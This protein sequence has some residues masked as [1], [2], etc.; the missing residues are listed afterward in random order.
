V[1]TRG[2]VTFV[3]DGAEKTAYNHSD[4]YPDGLGLT[5]LEWLRQA[6][7]DEA[8]AI[9]A[10]GLR[11]VDP[12]SK[13]SPGDIERLKGFANAGVGTQSLDDWYVLLRETQG[14]PALM[15]EAGVIEDAHE[16]PRS[17]L[18]AEWGYV[19]DFD[20]KRFEVY[21]GFQRSRHSAGRFAGREPSKNYYPVAL[22]AAW[23]FD[24]L[25]A[26]AD[27]MAALNDPDEGE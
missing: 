9:R 13:P 18:F 4:S 7:A 17:S 25:P 21:R 23:A 19:A 8:T 12:E 3:I 10:R 1:S 16:F 2:F 26:D 14:E 6:A 11:V 20:E 5:M 22:K 24:S 27:F 15:L